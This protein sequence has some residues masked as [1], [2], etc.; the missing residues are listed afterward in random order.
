[1]KGLYKMVLERKTQKVLDSLHTLGNLGEHNTFGQANL[2]KVFDAIHKA[3]M[4]CK[5]QL[6]WKRQ[7]YF[8]L[9]KDELH[10]EMK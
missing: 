3:T 10:G 8:T 7:K 2:H 1:M 5:G 4:E 6:G 9:A